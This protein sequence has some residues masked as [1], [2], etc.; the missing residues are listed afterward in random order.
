VS[1]PTETEYVTERHTFGG[2]GPEGQPDTVD[3]TATAPQDEP[4]AEPE[5]EPAAP[6]TRKAKS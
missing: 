3:E 1:E 2:E 5:A 4:D 6:K